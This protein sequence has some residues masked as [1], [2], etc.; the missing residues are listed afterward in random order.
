ME[1]VN[2]H[3]IFRIF[4]LWQNLTAQSYPTSWCLC[5]PAPPDMCI[6][7]EQARQPYVSRWLSS[8]IIL[9]PASE[10][11][12]GMYGVSPLFSRFS[13]FLGFLVFSVFW[14]SRFSGFL[15]FLV[16]WFSRFH[17][18]HRSGH[19]AW[20]SCLARLCAWPYPN[21]AVDRYCSSHLPYEPC[22]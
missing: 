5:P 14:F 3:T 15:G 12:P 9:S 22:W 13:R 1:L 7:D 16:F 19:V 21:K 6:I 4:T 8:S 18:S 10:T 17:A 2:H 11:C 20:I